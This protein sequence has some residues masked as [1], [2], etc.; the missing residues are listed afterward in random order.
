MCMRRH[1]GRLIMLCGFEDFC[2]AFGPS[3]R[4]CC[5]SFCTFGGARV[6]L[7]VCARASFAIGSIEAEEDEKKKGIC[8]VLIHD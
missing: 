7:T 5:L 1:C 3:S 2:L 4:W 6:E 8:I